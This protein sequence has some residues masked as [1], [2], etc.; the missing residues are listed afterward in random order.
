M[1]WLGSL[2]NAA[3]VGVGLLNG[4]MNPSSGAQ[5][6]Y[7]T[8]LVKA[9]PGHLIYVRQKKDGTARKFRLLA[10]HVV[11][12]ATR[13]RVGKTYTYYDSGAV[14]DGDVVFVISTPPGGGNT[15]QVI[16]NSTTRD[17]YVNFGQTN[18]TAALSTQNVAV[19]RKDGPYPNMVDVTYQFQNFSL[20]NLVVTPVQIEA[21]EQSALIVSPAAQMIPLSTVLGNIGFASVIANTIFSL[22]NS[23]YGN[24]QIKW[25]ANEEGTS[26][27]SCVV[28]NKT[29]WK[30]TVS[31]NVNWSNPAIGATVNLTVG[32]NSQSSQDLPDNESPISSASVCA[33]T[34]STTVDA[35]TVMK[36]H[37]KLMKE[38]NFRMY[39]A[40]FTNPSQPPRPDCSDSLSADQ[41]LARVRALG[42]IDV[43]ERES[44]KKAAPA[45]V[46]SADWDE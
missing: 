28:I 4:I 21:A 30:V 36:G 9:N 14:N 40:S 22:Y 32:G 7:E 37:N 46:A 6:D 41:L 38:S 5:V 12:S 35:K 34:D 25:V 29:S 33:F 16:N 1:S 18:A 45:A 43:L 13:A 44:K 23:I 3:K 2:F 19:G 15:L 26:I 42:G 11:V 31:V 39:H 27:K 10:A 17:Y 20:G 8:A 24:V